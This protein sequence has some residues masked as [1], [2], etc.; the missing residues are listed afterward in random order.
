[1][2]FRT[3]TLSV[4]GYLG[5]IGVAQATL[6]PYRVLGVNLVFQDDYGPTGLTWTATANLAASET[7]GLPL[8]TNLGFYPGDTSGEQGRIG[9]NGPMNWAGALFWIDAMNGS[10]YGGANDWRLWSALNADGSGPCGWVY[11]CTESELGYLFYVEG[12]LTPNHAANTSPTLSAVF[13]G[14]QSDV[15]WSGTQYAPATA[16]AWTFDL[17]HGGQDI[18][19]KGFSVYGWAVRPG[20]VTAAP[21][22]GTALLVWLG[23]LALRGHRGTVNS[24]A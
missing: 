3:T 7:F 12:G 18:Y 13:Q 15:Y 11:N 8:S 23:L 14:L 9:A 16:Y 22:P 5:F 10:N 6:V 24:G 19:T 1:M 17:G 21:L 2:K 20:R 4:L